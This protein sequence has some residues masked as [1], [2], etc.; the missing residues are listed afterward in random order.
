M[1]LSRSKSCLRSHSIL[2]KI[3]NDFIGFCV[4]SCMISL[5]NILQS[6]VE[7]F[8]ACLRSHTHPIGS[9]TI[10]IASLPKERD[11]YTVIPLVLSHYRLQNEIYYIHSLLK[12]RAT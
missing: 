9:C 10:T 11:F 3:N 7:S 5:F 2:T 4:G 6:A 8:L 12:F 1:L